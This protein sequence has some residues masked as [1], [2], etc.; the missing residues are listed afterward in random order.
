[1]R[2]P[3]LVDCVFNPRQGTCDPLDKGVVSL[4]NFSTNGS[5]ADGHYE[6]VCVCVFHSPFLSLSLSLSFSFSVYLLKEQKPMWR[7]KGKNALAKLTE[8]KYKDRKRK[9]S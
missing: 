5:S 3:L 8:D 7:A 9:Q 2:D 4:S 1:M 6:C